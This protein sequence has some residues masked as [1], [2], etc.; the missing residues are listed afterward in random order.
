M[1]ARPYAKLMSPHAHTRERQPGAKITSLL[2]FTS[3]F[4]LALF[5]SGCSGTTSAIPN[6]NLSTANSTTANSSNTAGQLTSS[7][8]TLNF[9]NVSQG[10][11][12]TLKVT[13]TNSTSSQ[14]TISNVSLSGG[15]FAASGIP[16]GTNLNATQTAALSVTFTPAATG[17]ASG[18]VTVTSNA[19]NSSLTILLQGSG[20]QPG[21]HLATL[22]WNP[23]SSSING[24]FVYRGV[25]P[26]GPYARLSALISTGA[27]YTDSTVQAGQLYYYVVT[28]VGTNNVE[29]YFSN[30]VS[31]TIPS[32]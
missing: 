9:G 18:S 3:I 30:E 11:N 19:P 14:V 22:L 10:S 23:V 15:G 7:S 8:S 1:T 31:A 6:A 13:L 28:A 29:S 16:A 27:T 24:Y 21:A 5:Q 26:G 4:L 20:V 2:A 12:S 17:S 32:P 25:T